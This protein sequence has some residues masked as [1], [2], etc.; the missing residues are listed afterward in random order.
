MALLEVRDITMRFSGVRALDGVD[1]DIEPGTITGLIGPNGA[2]KTTLFDII[3]GVQPPTAGMV[4]IDG[5]AITRLPPYRRCRRGIARTFQRIELF[6]SLT[7]LENVRVAAE[8][9]RRKHPVEVATELLQ[10]VGVEHLAGQIAGD[11]PT[12]A[13]RLVE[14]AR[15]LATQPRVLLLDEPVSGLDD[16]ETRDFGTLLGLLRAQGVAVLLV[17]HDMSLVMEVCDR[18]YVLDLGKV[19]AHGE[20]HQVRR[21]PQV[22]AAYLGAS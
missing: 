2:G 17:E 18:V 21:E 22:L 10:F 20:P 15:A 7:V 16:Q 12:G 6:G 5:T 1:L 14:V 8:I 9:S 4:R 13:A 19:I 11:L 3:S